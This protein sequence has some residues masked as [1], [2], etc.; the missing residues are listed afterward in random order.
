M[1]SLN[2]RSGIALKFNFWNPER[3]DERSGSGDRSSGSGRRR[4]VRGGLTCR[5]GRALHGPPWDP[6]APAHPFAQ[7]FP[8][9]GFADAGRE[10]RAQRRR[11]ASAPV[12]PLCAPCAGA[13][14]AGEEDAL[15]SDGR[16]R[17]GL[18]V[19]YKG[20]TVFSIS[21]SL[22]LAKISRKN[23]RLSIRAF[24]A[25]AV[26]LGKP[27]RPSSPFPVPLRRRWLAP[28]LWPAFVPPFPRAC[29]QPGCCA[30]RWRERRPE[31]S[32]PWS[33]DAP[34]RPSLLYLGR[35]GPELAGR[36]GPLFC[37]LGRELGGEE[38]RGGRGSAIGSRVG[39]EGRLG[40]S[41]PPLLG[42]WPRALGPL[43]WAAPTGSRPR[44]P[45]PKE[46]CFLFF[47]LVAETSKIH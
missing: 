13:V 18:A 25:R 10:Y 11:H 44:C 42:P 45:V 1:S 47:F 37:D 4:R 29:T 34:A 41:A 35:A 39:W 19:S 38:V 3:S 2:R 23:L 31:A 6:R 46:I 17:A 8:C 32:P 15:P 14:A 20:S 43:P 36:C 28:W 7:A 9:P 22:S 12:L 16:A 30:R 24:P 33:G 26:R 21:L 5:A 40:L 27:P